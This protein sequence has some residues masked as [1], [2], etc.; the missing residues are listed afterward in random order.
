MPFP[1]TGQLQGCFRGLV[2]LLGLLRYLRK[3]S[4]KLKLELGGSFCSTGR[5]RFSYNVHMF[6]VRRRILVL[7][8][9]TMSIC[10]FSVMKQFWTRVA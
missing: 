2:G 7:C 4:L 9:A 3:L 1:L 10:L 6:E 8:I 5:G